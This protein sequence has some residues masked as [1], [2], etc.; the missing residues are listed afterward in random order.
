MTILLLGPSTWL[1]GK[2]LT[3]PGPLRG[4]PAGSPPGSG[5]T[6][7]TPLDLRVALSEL[8]ARHGVPALVMEVEEPR[9]PPNTTSKFLTLVRKHRVDEYFAI[10]P[11][12]A[13]RPGLDVEVGF[14]LL[15]MGRG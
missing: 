6:A 9:D 15:Q 3:D 12:G 13:A 5:P 14:L 2:H 11:F 8:L 7:V 10:W 4:I 1:P